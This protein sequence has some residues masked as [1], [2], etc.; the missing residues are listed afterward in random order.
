MEL[1]K[2]AENFSYK[3]AVEKSLKKSVQ[4]CIPEL[5]DLFSRIFTTDPEDR[6]NWIQIREHQLFKKY[7]P[8]IPEAS[9]TFYNKKVWL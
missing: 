1:L 4:N 5:E 7:F 6:I 2:Q 8:V 9:K 3:A